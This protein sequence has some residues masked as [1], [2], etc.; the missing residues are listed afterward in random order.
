MKRNLGFTNVSVNDVVNCLNLS[1]RAE[2]SARNV[3]SVGRVK[4]MDLD[5]LLKLRKNADDDLFVVLLI[6]KNKILFKSCLLKK[7]AEEN[8]MKLDPIEFEDDEEEDDSDV[9]TKGK[10]FLE[11]RREKQLTKPRTDYIR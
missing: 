1:V 8:M 11:Q 2:Q 4:M 6:K 9:F 3:P 7:D 10:S 5:D